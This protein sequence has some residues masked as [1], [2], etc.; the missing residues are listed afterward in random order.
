[1]TTLQEA[2]VVAIIADTTKV[3]QSDIV[4]RPDE[5]IRGA[6]QFRVRVSSAERNDLVL[7]GWFNHHSGKLSYTLLTHQVGRIYGLDLGANHNNENG[8][9]LIGTH[10]VRWTPEDQDRLAY[11]PEDITAEWWEPDTV[12][13]QFCAEANLTHA[14]T[15]MGPIHEEEVLP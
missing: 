12:W 9:R 7:R 2:D 14:G 1:M 13:E 6:Q 11:K 4:W 3:V 5:S 15:M 10:K 8:E